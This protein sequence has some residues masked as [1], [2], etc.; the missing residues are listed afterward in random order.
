MRNT[1]YPIIHA[2]NQGQNV[3]TIGRDV[4]GK[5]GGDVSILANSKDLLKENQYFYTST[6]FLFSVIILRSK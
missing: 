4:P 3:G 5:G 2:G 1:I 6:D